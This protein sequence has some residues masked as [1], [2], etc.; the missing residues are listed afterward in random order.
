MGANQWRTNVGELP[1]RL[2]NYDVLITQALRK[3]YA[4][5]QESPP[6]PFP[7]AI[8]G[9]GTKHRYL[10]IYRKGLLIIGNTA[11][12]GRKTAQRFRRF[13]TESLLI[14][15]WLFQPRAL[16]RM[17]EQKL[18]LLESGTSLTLTRPTSL[19]SSTCAYIPSAVDSGFQ[20]PLS[21]ALLRDFAA[22]D[23]WH[24]KTPIGYPPAWHITAP[25][26]K[27]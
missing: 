2:S 20:K 14:H 12:R 13:Q 15:S 27:G 7:Q 16:R 11:E 26:C 21:P 5:K 10:I 17:T 22:E 19:P 3:S 9:T 8:S 4:G 18:K 25:W 1:G 24:L 23:T 6:R